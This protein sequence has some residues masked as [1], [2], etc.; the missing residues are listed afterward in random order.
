M[1]DGDPQNKLLAALGGIKTVFAA[2]VL[3]I[4]FLGWSLTRVV[5]TLD[6]TWSDS[7]LYMC[8]LLFGGMT[9]I[10]FLILKYKRSEPDML[11]EPKVEA[12]SI[13]DSEAE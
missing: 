6:G 10:V 7:R 11:V 4:I 12:T 9:L 3:C 5:A 2:L 8:L 13:E 1:T